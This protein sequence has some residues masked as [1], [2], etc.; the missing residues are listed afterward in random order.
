MMVFTGEKPKAIKE[1]ANIIAGNEYAKKILG[2]INNAEKRV[3]VSM[4]VMRYSPTRSYAIEN[5]YIKALINRHK[6]GVDIKVVLD[7][8]KEWSKKTRRLSGPPSDKNDDAFKVLKKNGVP[9]LYDSM[10]QIMHAKT[11]I[12]DDDLFVIGSTNWTY[13][14]LK[15]NVEF[16]V[17]IKSKAKTQK[18]AD[19]FDKLWSACKDKKIWIP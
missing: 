5:E 19:Y 15:K 10:D 1:G 18:M 11:I 9:V 2:L 12:I 14:A 4:Y 16:S 6:K 13:S 7:A 8:S 17:L 3:Y